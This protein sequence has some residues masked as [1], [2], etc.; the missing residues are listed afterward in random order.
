MT[1][2]GKYLFFGGL[3]LAALGALLWGAGRLGI[4]LGKLPGDLHWQ[5]ER[6]RVYFP[7][8]TC[9]VLSLLLTLLANFLG[10]FLR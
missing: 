6:T 7:I 9:I 10:R 5:G 8:V 1:G 4:P 2:L 3:F